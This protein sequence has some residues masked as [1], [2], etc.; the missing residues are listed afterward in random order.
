MDWGVFFR[1]LV[2]FTI[3]IAFCI[4]WV[5]LIMYLASAV[6]V[7]AAMAAF[8]AVPATF[9]AFGAALN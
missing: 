2:M 7:W 3:F 8:L 9:L 6:G 1:V 4:L 5:H